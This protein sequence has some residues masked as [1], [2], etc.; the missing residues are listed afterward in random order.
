[1]PGVCCSTG[2]GTKGDGLIAWT[3]RCVHGFF[4]INVAPGVP[5]RICI[6]DVAGN[7][8]LA[9]GAQDQRF[10]VKVQ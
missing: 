8:A 2:V 7:H 3:G 9:F 4:E 10:G 6:G 5:R 1:M